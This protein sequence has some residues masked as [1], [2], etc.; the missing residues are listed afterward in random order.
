MKASSRSL[1]GASEETSVTLASKIYD[2]IAQ[3]IMVGRL[4][5]GQR[6]EEQ[7]LAEQ[8]GVSRTP[9]RE[10]LRELC[11]RELISLVP[12]R[13][14]VVA[15]LHKDKIIEML[16]AEC[17][18][19]GLCARL[20]AQRMSSL[21]KDRLQQMHEEA[22][23][24]V[25]TASWDEYFESNREFHELI[26]TGAHNQTLA[27]TTRDLRIRLRAF[28]TNPDQDHQK[29]MA[30]SHQDHS[31]IVAAIVR[32]RADQAYEAMRAHNARVNS[33]AFRI[34]DGAPNAR[35]GSP[36]DAATTRA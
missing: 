13:G 9:I 16:D 23:S 3:Q 17:E 20:A 26:C 4:V 33:T 25:E 31:R 10:A 2:S 8:F 36:P 24:L 7:V 14:A 21:E 15:S 19:E 6:L 12:R 5:P 22:L 32:G 28:R 29:A 35:S 30:R 18:I 1:T 34:L 27:S 11:A